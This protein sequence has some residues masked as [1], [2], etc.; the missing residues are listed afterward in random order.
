MYF[1][2]EGLFLKCN[3]TNF[4]KTSF[5]PTGFISVLWDNGHRYPYPYGIHGHF[6]VKIV[7]EPRILPEDQL[8]DVGCL[9]KRG[10]ESCLSF[11]DTKLA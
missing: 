6:A 10:T 3:V 11:L 5:F 4:L 2:S 9:V 8:I 7:D 1:D